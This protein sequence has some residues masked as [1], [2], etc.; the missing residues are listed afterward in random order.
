MGS[1]FGDLDN[2]GFLDLY[3][4]TG[5]APLD[6]LMPNR[7]F[8]NDHGRKFLDVTTSSGTGHLQKGHGAYEGDEYYSA[9]FKNPGTKNNW[10]KLKLVGTVTNKSALGARIKVFSK[11]SG[12]TKIVYRTVNSGSSRGA[13]PLVQ[14]IGL[15]SAKIIEK[16]EVYWPASKKTT[17]T[18]NVAVNQWL[19]LNEDGQTSSPPPPSQTIDTKK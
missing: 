2:D 12:E 6:Y 18:K 11:Q 9:L 4:G 1:N 17:L 8:W 7:M 15:G 13:N 3:L 19:I 5:A 10:L 16:I 14:H